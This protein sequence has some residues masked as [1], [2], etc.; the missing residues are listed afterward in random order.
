MQVNDQFFG[1]WT[2]YLSFGT[3]YKVNIMQ[4]I[5]IIIIIIIINLF[6]QDSSISETTFYIE[7]LH[8]KYT[9]KGKNIREKSGNRN[10]TGSQYTLHEKMRDTGVNN[11]DIRKLKIKKHC[12]YIEQYC[13][14]NS[15]KNIISILIQI[16]T[17]HFS[18]HYD[19]KNSKT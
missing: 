2:L 9:K 14:K 6:R 1:S 12:S 11:S 16:L 15:N 17:I 8:N 4:L 5:I 10:S 3:C 13:Q 18:D 19:A 7:V